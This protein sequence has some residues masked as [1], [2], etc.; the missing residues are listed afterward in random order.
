MKGVWR[1]ENLVLLVLSGILEKN[2]CLMF[3]LEIL[4]L[5]KWVVFIL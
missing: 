3:I 1:W 2:M 5:R 4:V